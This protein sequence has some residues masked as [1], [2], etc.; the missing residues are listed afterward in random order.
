MGKSSFVINYY[1]H[2]LKLQKRKRH[3][4]AVVP[5]GI[6]NALE[7]IAR[8]DNKK[9]TVI[10]LDAFDEDTEAIK[11]HARRL[12]ELMRACS[13]YR[14]VLI[15]CRT[16][17]FPSDEEIPQ[18]TGIARV[19]PRLPGEPAVYEFWKLYLSPL[20]DTQVDKFIRQRY[21]IWRWRKRNQARALVRK[22]P[23]LSVRPMLL[24]YTPDLIESRTAHFKYAFQVYE[25]MI[26]KWLERESGWIDPEVLLPFSEKLA[27]N[28]FTERSRRGAERISRAELASILKEETV[29][30]DD[31]KITGRSL[32]NRDALGNLK[33]AHRS[34]LEYL[35]VKRFA[36]GEPRRQRVELTDNMKTFLLEM[37]HSAYREKDRPV[38]VYQHSDLSNAPHMRMEPIY[39]LRSVPKPIKDIDQEFNRMGYLTSGINFLHE[40]I[41]VPEERNKAIIVT[42]Y[43]SRL[44][45]QTKGSKHPLVL[46]SAQQYVCRMNDSLYAGYSKWRLPTL[47]ELLSMVGNGG[48]GLGLDP[49]FDPR[50]DAIWTSDFTAD[51]D[52]AIAVFGKR[53]GGYGYEE[54][55]VVLSVIINKTPLNICAI[56]QGSSGAVR[57]GSQE[58]RARYA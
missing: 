10:F 38:P 35:V 11:D 33:F 14:R 31:W 13:G 43:A 28:L 23:F 42:D 7:A 56:K 48:L 8:I 22:I 54:V 57:A 52:D 4:L 5:L 15:T 24:A 25:V 9:E 36:I 44:Q 17:F 30:I 16:Q 47:S 32:L 6:P 18:Q 12:H 41:Y 55:K 49:L 3:R 19:A 50:V 27:V 21:P 20:N 29:R 34:I 46:P 58:S 37:I 26:R 51:T 2:N 39:V 53:P 40:H 1:A 45:W